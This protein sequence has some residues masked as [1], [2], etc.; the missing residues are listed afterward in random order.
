MR[1]LYRQFVWAVPADL[2]PTSDAA[3]AALPETVGPVITDL[4]RRSTTTEVG[5][6][7]SAITTIAMV[8]TCELERIDSLPY[9]PD[10]EAQSGCT[11]CRLGRDWAKT[12]LMEYPGRHLVVGIATIEVPTPL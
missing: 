2:E 6:P 5:H 1:T 8:V 12:Y 9:A 3:H 4:V 11:E 10:C 7:L